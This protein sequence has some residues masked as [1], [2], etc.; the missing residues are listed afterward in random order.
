LIGCLGAV[1]LAIS[2]NFYRTAVELHIKQAWEIGQNDME[3]V[4]ITED[5]DPIIPDDIKNPP[6][7]KVLENL[8]KWRR[9]WSY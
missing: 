2:S 3:M 1:L 9:R 4:A 5:D 8:K 7:Q 6:V